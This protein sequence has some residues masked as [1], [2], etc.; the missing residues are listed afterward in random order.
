[1]HVKAVDDAGHDRFVTLKARARARGGSGGPLAAE[2]K[3]RAAR[4]LGSSFLFARDS[5]IALLL[6]PRKPSPSMTSTQPRLLEAVD[7]MVRQLVARLWAD[8][9]AGGGPYALAV[10]GDHS[11]PVAFGDHSHEPVPFAVAHLEHVVAALGGEERVL[12]TDLGRV[13]LP[14]VKAPPAAAELAAQAAQQAARR[15]ACHAGVAFEG[16]VGPELG[17]W[18]EPWPQ[19]TAGDGV[20][21]FDETSAARGALGRFPGSQAM[22]IIKQACGVE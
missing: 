4:L 16:A 1:V 3:K 19:A 18:A 20:R 8:Q 13:P 2:G 17:A 12:A 22:A 14:D 11:T 21:F 15:R 7:V 10:T 5:H 6:D 9:A